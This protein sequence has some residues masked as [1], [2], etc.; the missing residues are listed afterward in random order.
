[1]YF[2]DIIGQHEAKAK[3][4]SMFADNRIPHALMLDLFTN[5]IVG[6]KIK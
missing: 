6:T 4:L 1:V 2:K 5:Q 3:L